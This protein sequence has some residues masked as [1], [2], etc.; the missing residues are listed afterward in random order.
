MAVA[1]SRSTRSSISSSVSYDKSWHRQL[2]EAITSR[3]CGVA[4]TFCET[5][6]TEGAGHRALPPDRAQLRQVARS[7][8]FSEAR[9]LAARFETRA[10]HLPRA[11]ATVTRL[12]Q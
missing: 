12:A 9:N 8:E 1:A 2:A 11:A 5:R 4:A 6:P 10:D 3:R 7:C